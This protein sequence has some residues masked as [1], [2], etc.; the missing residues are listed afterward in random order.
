[1]SELA[2]VLGTDKE[3]EVLARSWCQVEKE[4]IDFGVMEKADSVV[5]VPVEMGWSDIGSW[6]SLIE[7]LPADGDGNVVVGNHLGLETKGSLIYS[8][9]RLVATVGVENLIIVETE[10][11][12]LI[13]PRE[14]AQEVK[15]LVDRL[16]EE[17]W[18]ECL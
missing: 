18:Q 11:A 16:E 8:P 5:V 1:L 6:A 12:I 4:T 10:D 9:R 15:R 7:L 17:G 3:E 2:G 14:R 13:C